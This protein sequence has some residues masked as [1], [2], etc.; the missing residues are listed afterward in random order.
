[1]EQE[2]TFSELRRRADLAEK[3][4][5]EAGDSKRAE[6]VLSIAK[7]ALEQLKHITDP[8]GAQTI[9]TGLRIRGVLEIAAGIGIYKLGEHFVG[10]FGNQQEIKDVILWLITTIVACMPI[11]DGIGCFPRARQAKILS[12][13][14]RD[15]L[16]KDNSKIT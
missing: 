14:I 2:K 4:L 8:V 7:S 16:R 1:M 15:V 3:V 13:D 6:I 11:I 5:A 10:G 12:A 9:A